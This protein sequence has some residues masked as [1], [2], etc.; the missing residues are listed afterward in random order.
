MLLV[1]AL[2][3][4]ALLQRGEPPDV[5]HQRANARTAARSL[6][7]LLRE[8]RLVVTHGNGP[9]V[10]NL[11]RA[12]AA[13]GDAVPPLDVLDA[14]TEGLIGYLLAQELHNA[15]PTHEVVTL[16]TQVLVDPADPAFRRPD[17]PIGPWYSRDDAELVAAA[18]GWTMAEIDGR[19]RRVVPS[20]SPRAI[21]ELPAIRTLVE[22]GFVTIAV[23]GG[24]IPVAETGDGERVGVEAVVD[25]DRAAALLALALGADALLLLTDV[26]GAYT[27]WGTADPRRIARAHPDALVAH[28][29]AP[30]SMGPKVEAAALFAREAGTATIA[31]LQDAPAALLGTAG[32]VVTRAARGI[33]LAD[34][35]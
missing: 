29:F 9:Q 12:A 32:T 19:W 21:I 28:P 1:V 14:E 7:P 5:A 25:K 18:Q 24:G 20:P 30:G 8:H 13:A 17:K 16:L 35:S 4:N 3:G 6:A 2:G 27:G 26:D 10:G 15:A 11:A 23:G 31:A 22:A 34:R 33:T